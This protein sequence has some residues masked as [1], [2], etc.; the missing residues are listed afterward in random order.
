MKKRGVAIVLLANVLLAGG[1]AAYLWVSRPQPLR[2]FGTV[3]ADEAS[4][5]SL[6]G[7]R[8]ESVHVEEGE[9]IE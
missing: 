6:V 2:F 1:A 8:V 9:R 4:A 7:A 5:G 3:E